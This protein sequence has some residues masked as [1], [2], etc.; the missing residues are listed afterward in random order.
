[1]TI[2]ELLGLIQKEPITVERMLDEELVAHLLP[3]FPK[4]RPTD[5]GMTVEDVVGDVAK[6]GIM[7]EVMAKREAKKEVVKGRRFVLK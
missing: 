7:A 6:G 5:A 3:Y 2:E 1:M 4:T